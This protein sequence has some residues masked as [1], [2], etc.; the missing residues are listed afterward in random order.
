MSRLTAANNLARLSVSMLSL[1]LLV[2][3][4]Q[5]HGYA[6]AG[7]LVLVYA[8]TNAAAGPVR[9][10]LADRFRP[11]VVLLSLLAVHVVAFVLLC[12]ALAAPM[13]VLVVACLLLGA[14]V[15]PTGPVV[16][17]L[18]PVLIP[19][20]RLATAYAFDGA[21]NN[22]TFVAGPVLAGVLLLV[23]PAQV[24]VAVTGVVKVTGD[25][26]VATAPEVR[27]MPVHQRPTHLLGPLVHGRIR[28]LL[29][30]MALDTFTYGCL[31]VAAV[32][33]ASG[34]GSAGVL[35]GLLA[36]GSVVSGLAYGAR[37]WPGIAGSQL[38]VL[39]GAGV[40]VLAAGAGSSGMVL[41]GAVFAAY[42]LV[43]GPVETVK[44]VLIGEGSQAH[45]RVEVFSWVFSVMWLGFGVGTTVAGQ[46]S[47]SGET[48]PAL[49]IATGAQ[50][51]AVTLTAARLRH[52][53]V[54]AQ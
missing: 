32:A 35:T 33:A 46:V 8:I 15:P 31:E 26:L 22:A 40:V 25:A 6:A 20:E 27:D 11:R 3:V 16:R 10:R 43:N 4:T 51:I 13:A 50:L 38:V 7:L 45:Q 1:S 41:A 21:L 30:L 12:V 17:G 54:V 19:K 24:A 18:W 53:K 48:T 42:G 29:T 2:A 14:S 47:S 28:L 23:L 9:G 34:R 49:V 52:A 44:Q 37:T 39:T 5:V 36:L